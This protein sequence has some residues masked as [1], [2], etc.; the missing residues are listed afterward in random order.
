MAHVP[1]H[2]RWPA[3]L[4]ALLCL[5]LSAP[6]LARAA[7]LQVAPTMLELLPGQEAEALWISNSGTE[8]VQVQVRL[9]RW[10]QSGGADDLQP[11]QALL[12]SPPMQELAAGQRQLIR[13]MRA[14]AE[15][16]DTQQSY[17][18]IVDEVPA[19]D[20]D[21]TGMQFVLR[22][23][24]P[25]FLQPEGPAPQ[26]RLLAQ[27]IGDDDGM[28]WIQ[29]SNHGDGYAQLAD[30]AHGAPERPLVVRAGLVGYVLPGQTMQWSLEHP[31]TRFLESGFS[32]RI[33]GE[34]EQTP[35]PAAP[36]PR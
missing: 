3:S 27:V 23:S 8:P 31:P 22:Y 13:V 7:S 33:N 18:I 12:V 35:L 28:A 11:T 6:T 5:S 20:P 15:T 29:V 32:A 9:F 34:S 10:T 30:L 2:R 14:G 21:R 1:I 4:A 25:V 36:A 26:P 24:I 19:F 17:R 16:P